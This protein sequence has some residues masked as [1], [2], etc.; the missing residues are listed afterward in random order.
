MKMYVAFFI[1]TPRVCN[2]NTEW[3]SEK[4]QIS[5]RLLQV[6]QT[7]NLNPMDYWITKYAATYKKECTR[8]KCKMLM[9]CVSACDSWQ[10]V[11]QSITD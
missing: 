9:Y 11:N 1:E 8:R 10:H 5:S 7:W 4:L 6:A 3:Q 2:L